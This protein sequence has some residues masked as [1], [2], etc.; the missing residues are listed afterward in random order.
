MVYRF[1]VVVVLL[2]LAVSN[3][4]CKSYPDPP[5][6]AFSEY[7]FKSEG[8]DLRIAVRPITDKRESKKYF[9]KH[10]AKSGLVPVQIIYFND[11]TNRIYTVLKEKIMYAV[12]E[13]A[14]PA[15]QPDKNFHSKAGKTLGVVSAVAISPIGLLASGALYARAESL[16][17]NLSKKELRDQS[18][19][20]GG[21][22]SGFIFIPIDK[23]QSGLPIRLWIN[24]F[25][26]DNGESVH[27]FSL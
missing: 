17:H 10:L 2:S 20:P 11:S 1:A 22:T 23:E 15:E 9:G 3:G 12:G 27:D 25:S 6:R 24:G 7:H 21:S 16:K 5:I 18:L 8:N 4:Y 13:D 19:A 26:D 14:S